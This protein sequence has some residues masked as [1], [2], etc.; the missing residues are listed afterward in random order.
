MQVSG[1]DHQPDCKL[2]GAKC[3]FIV[4]IDNQ[5]IHIFNRIENQRC[6][7]CSAFQ[8]HRKMKRI[9]QGEAQL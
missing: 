4:Q 8:I 9:V 5:S 1:N 2:Q 7:P 6:S 3:R